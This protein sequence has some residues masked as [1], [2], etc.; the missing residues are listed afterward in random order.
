M[1][2]PGVIFS[3]PQP[4]FWLLPLSTSHFPPK[5]VHMPADALGPLWSSYLGSP[6]LLPEF[7][8]GPAW[9][10]GPPFCCCLTPPPCPSGLG[11]SA[12]ILVPFQGFP[13][14]PY[15]HP[16][17]SHTVCPLFSH[18]TLVLPC[19][20]LYYTL[21]CTR[22]YFYIGLLLFTAFSLSSYEIKDCLLHFL[23]PLL[24]S[25]MTHMWLNAH[26]I[27]SEWVYYTHCPLLY[28]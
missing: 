26:Q 27:L 24:S 22:R 15:D 1:S 21:S 2:W 10:W 4:L 25:I 12:Q 17:P 28:K 19:L 14:P 13:Q 7:S 20:C 5:G 18:G 16:F 9:D 11:S 8:S 23:V 3:E 6:G